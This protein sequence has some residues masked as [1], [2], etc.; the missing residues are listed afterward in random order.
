MIAISY[1]FNPVIRGLEKMKFKTDEPKGMKRGITY[2]AKYSKHKIYKGRDGIIRFAPREDDAYSKWY[3]IMQWRVADRIWQKYQ[4]TLQEY[5]KNRQ[6]NKRE[7]NMAL[8]NYI[9]TLVAWKTLE[10]NNG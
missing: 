9:N 10:F 6:A 2:K 5:A 7:F 1:N 8:K 3:R 4:K